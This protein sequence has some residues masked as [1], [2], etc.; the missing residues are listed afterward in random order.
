MRRRFGDLP[1]ERG[2]YGKMNVRRQIVFFGRL[3]G[4]GRA[5][6]ATRAN[7]WIERLGLTPYADRP[8]AELSKGNQQKVQIACAAIHR[9]ELLILDE[10]FAGLDPVNA[11][12][13][14]EILNEL[15]AG[16]TTLVLSSHQLWQLEDLC[17]RFCIVVAG[18]NHAAG[19]LAELRAAWPTRRLRVAPDTT[20]V[21]DVLARIA[22]ARFDASADGCV[23][24]QV[25]T[26]TT[27]P[28][29]LRRLVDVEGVTSFE[30][31][32]PSLADIYLH[33]IG[34]DR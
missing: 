2:L 25:P 20:A 16:G 31:I 28:D 27:L 32:E 21:R 12:H 10:P 9:P 1:E 4:L 11:Q 19:T 34:A 29:L 24:Y 6:A 3:H 23:D 14:L 33:A 18:E 22:G 5:D 26:A 13:L 17:D 8:C 7:R 30:A 15:K